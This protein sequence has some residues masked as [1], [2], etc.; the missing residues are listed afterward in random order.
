MSS[1]ETGDREAV[2]VPQIK[3]PH[4]HC[5]PD[6]LPKV[7]SVRGPPMLKYRYYVYAARF[8]IVPSIFSVGVTEIYAFHQNTWYVA[9]V[10]IT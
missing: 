6:L 5:C 8:A 4:C 3:S 1:R 10:H 9:L 7:D 2:K